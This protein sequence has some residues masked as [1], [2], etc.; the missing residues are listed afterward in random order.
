MDIE[1]I[2]AEGAHEYFVWDDNFSRVVAT[3]RLKDGEEGTEI[4]MINVERGMRG[5]GLGTTLLKRLVEDFSCST[6]YAWVFKGRTDWY[7]RNGFKI[8]TTDGDLVKVAAS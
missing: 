6:L 5:R 1:R 2:S 7:E 3:A 8:W 4:L